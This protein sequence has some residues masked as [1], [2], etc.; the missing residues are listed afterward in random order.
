MV[1]NGRNYKI[2]ADNEAISSRAPQSYK[3][4]TK[5]TFSERRPLCF[6]VFVSCRYFLLINLKTIYYE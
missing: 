2:V 3:T 1:A 4:R 5:V 6:I